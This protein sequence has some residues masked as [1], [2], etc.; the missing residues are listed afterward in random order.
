MIHHA[1]QF[2]RR[3][4]ARPGRSPPESAA[5]RSNARGGA[6][7]R[8]QVAVPPRRPRSFRGQRRDGAGSHQHV[9]A[10]AV[11]RVYCP[12]RRDCRGNLNG[13]HPPR[14]R[15]RPVATAS[16]TGSGDHRGSTP[17][18]LGNGLPTRSRTPSAPPRIRAPAGYI[19]QPL[20]R[21]MRRQGSPNPDIM[22]DNPR[23][24]ASAAG[25]LVKV[26]SAATVP[27]GM[28]MLRGTK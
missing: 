13:R 26:W 16:T 12:W 25:W 5:A 23:P 18:V 19:Q 20:M 11:C 7:S 2:P 14:W 21:D 9:R 8:A 22:R 17:A 15:Y 6:S 1:R 10:C 4:A 27:A 24:A 3:Q 28:T